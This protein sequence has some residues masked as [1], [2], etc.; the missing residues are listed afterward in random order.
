[1]PINARRFDPLW[2]GTEPQR[3]PAVNLAQENVIESYAKEEAMNRYSNI[4]RLQDYNDDGL[5]YCK[6]L[7]PPIEKVVS[8]YGSQQVKYLT[9]LLI[10]AA[11]SKGPDSKE[12]LK[13]KEYIYT[14]A[15]SEIEQLKPQK[16][17]YNKY[18]QAIT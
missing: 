1:M 7:L 15:N 2:G 6:T 14:K 4:V 3:L 11:T 17:L 12:V 9:K 10:S 13:L 5:R 16:I 8:T 18:G